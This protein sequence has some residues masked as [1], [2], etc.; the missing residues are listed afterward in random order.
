M[1]LYGLVQKYNLLKN[2]EKIS[3]HN[4]SDIRNIYN[5]L[6]SEEIKNNDPLNLPDGIFFRRKS[7]SVYSPHMKEIHRG[8]YVETE[9]I[10][11]NG[12]SFIYIA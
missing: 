9:I 8:I 1:R 5:E 3:I 10:A 12:K 6:V 7:V 4:C 2:S 11:C